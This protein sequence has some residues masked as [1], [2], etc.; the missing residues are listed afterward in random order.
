MASYKGTGIVF[1]RSL[2]QKKGVEQA[3]LSSLSEEEKVR[4]QRTI[5]VSWVAIEIVSAFITKATRVLYPGMSEKQALR[6]FGIELARDNIN[7]IYKIIVKIISLEYFMKQAAKLWQ[8]YHDSGEAHVERIGEKEL[9]FVVEKFAHMP[10]SIYESTGGYIT[11]MGMM[12]G[13]KKVEV[14]P[15]MILDGIK[16]HIRYV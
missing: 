5:S 3:F 9:A 15:E 6:E 12:S 13:L 16:W 4:Y 2:L 10:V 8:T 7:G 14:V 1:M 11:G